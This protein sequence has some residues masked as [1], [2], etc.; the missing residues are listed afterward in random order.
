M[1]MFD[2]K[3]MVGTRDK[4]SV[5]I[6]PQKVTFRILRTKKQNRVGV[7]FRVTIRGR[8]NRAGIEIKSLLLVEAMGLA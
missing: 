4:Y 8:S 6:C 3:L 7:E 1:S 2:I 5:P